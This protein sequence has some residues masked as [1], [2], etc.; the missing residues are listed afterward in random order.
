M[1]EVISLVGQYSD[2]IPQRDKPATGMCVCSIR[3]EESS[4][5]RERRL[6]QKT[7]WGSAPDGSHFLYPGILFIKGAGWASLLDETFYFWQHTTRCGS[8]FDDVAFYSCVTFFFVVA[9]YGRLFDTMNLASSW[10]PLSMVFV[11]WDHNRAGKAP[12]DIIICNQSILQWNYWRAAI[13]PHVM[14]HARFSKQCVWESFVRYV[15]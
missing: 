15:N 3:R 4:R 8:T 2:G 13:S 7:S 1:G 10:A 11:R 14:Q 9:A 6:E 5:R 12:V